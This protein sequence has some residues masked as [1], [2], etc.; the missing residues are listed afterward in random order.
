MQRSWRPPSHMIA[1]SE[2]ERV[3]LIH[4]FVIMTL[5]TATDTALDIKSDF[6]ISVCFLAFP[7]VQPTILAKLSTQKRTLLCCCCTSQCERRNSLQKLPPSC[8]SCW[9]AAS[10]GSFLALL[11]TSRFVWRLVSLP[12]V[13]SLRVAEVQPDLMAIRTQLSEYC[14]VQHAL[15]NRLLSHVIDLAIRP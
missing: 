4:C 5:P 11:S 9:L 7:I 3:D 10:A 15:A 6:V 8:K 12:P 14:S 1:V 2:R 13:C